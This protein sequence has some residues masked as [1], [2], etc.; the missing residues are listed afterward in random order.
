MLPF[1]FLTRLLEYFLPALR[2]E[3]LEKLQAGL[4]PSAP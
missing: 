2:P 3:E 1:A 4:S